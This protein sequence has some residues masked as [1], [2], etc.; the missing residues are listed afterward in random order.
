MN[1]VS[2]ETEHTIEALLASALAQLSVSEPIGA[3]KIAHSAVAVA[4]ENASLRFLYGSMLAGSGRPEEALEHLVEAVVL[5]GA[6]PV[7]F[8]QLG[9]LQ[10]F[11]GRVEEAR[12]SWGAIKPEEVDPDLACYVRAMQAISASRRDDA[13]F[14]LRAGLGKPSSNLPLTE[15]MRVLLE[16]LESEKIV[17][18]DADAKQHV[19]VGQYFTNSDKQ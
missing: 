5:K 18:T 11:N 19:L 8:F 2:A 13:L 10:Y 3:M 1:T 6:K 7:M 12:Q 4:P 15:N 14:E 16:S 17:G 9:M